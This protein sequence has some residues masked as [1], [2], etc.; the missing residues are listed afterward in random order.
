MHPILEFLAIDFSSAAGIS[1][2]YTQWQKASCQHST[3]NAVPRETESTIRKCTRNFLHLHNA[4]RQPGPHTARS[5]R[6]SFV[7]SSS[8]A[9]LLTVT[10]C[11]TAE[12][13]KKKTNSWR[14]AR[15]SIG[16]TTILFGSPQPAQNTSATVRS[17]CGVMGNECSAICKMSSS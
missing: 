16:F 5:K 15:F 17:C 14:S 8:S 2:L 7:A 6:S 13:K 3:M 11:S 12:L 1:N 10:S 9:I 4:R